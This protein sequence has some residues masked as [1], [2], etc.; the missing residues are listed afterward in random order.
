MPFQSQN[1]VA[2]P[3]YRSWFVKGLKFLFGKLSK[4]PGC[5][6]SV[7]QNTH[8]HI[9]T[10]PLPLESISFRGTCKGGL[11]CEAGVR[12]AG[13]ISSLVPQT[14]APQEAKQ[15]PKA[16]VTLLRRQSWNWSRLTGTAGVCSSTGHW[17]KH[18][19]EESLSVSPPSETI[20]I[21]MT[22]CCLKVGRAMMWLRS[23]SVKSLKKPPWII[24]DSFFIPYL[25]QTDHT[26]NRSETKMSLVIMTLKGSPQQI[27]K[28]DP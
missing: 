23:R 25:P 28:R 22:P 1:V 27:G 2:K 16:L 3:H 14:E 4:M 17:C 8:E 26:N 11:V 21:L 6:V 12:R 19:H 13:F 10:S 5:A 18:L 24:K 9:G 7:L 15:E 20:A